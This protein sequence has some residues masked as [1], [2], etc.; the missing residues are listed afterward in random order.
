MMGNRCVSRQSRID[1]VAGLMIIYMILYHIFQ[2]CD[3]REVNRSYW[4]QP[5]SFFMFWFF[6]KSGMFY[7]ERT[8]REILLG[9]GEVDDSLCCVQLDRTSGEVCENAYGR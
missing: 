1:A 8:C 7:K 4:M 6:Y 5:I 9:G 3:L 2:W